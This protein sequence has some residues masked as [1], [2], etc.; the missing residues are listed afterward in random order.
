[1][2][3][4]ESLKRFWHFFWHEES[5]ASYIVFFIVAYLLLKFVAFPIFLFALGLSDV[6]AVMSTSM[7]HTN[8]NFDAT[9]YV[10][11]E[12]HNITRAQTADWPFSNGLNI[13]DVIFVDKSKRA[14]IALGDVIVYYAP[15]GVSI[16]HRVVNIED[17]IFTT[18]GD[19]NQE[20]LN[21]ESNVP[22]ELIKGEAIFKIPVLGYPRVILAYLIGR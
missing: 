4:K 18:K 22:F 9:Y 10:W 15:T 1:M 13:G 8:P 21:F 19:A 17:G 6:T 7:V 20:P 3:I 16:I 2:K 5:I 11:L 14:D 12:Q